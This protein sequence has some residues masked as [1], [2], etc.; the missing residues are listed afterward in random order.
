V[1]ASGDAVQEFISEDDLKTFDGWLKY[2]GVEAAT[3]APEEMAVLQGLFDEARKHSSA[4]PKVGLMKLEPVPGEH[5][6]AVAVREGSDLWLALWVRRSRKGEFFVML[7]RLDRDWDVHASYHLDGTRH[8]KSYD[9]RVLP[10]TKCQPLAGTF[11]GTENLETF[12]GYG[13]KSV[14]AICDPTAFSGVVEIAPGILGPRDGQITVDLV[15]PGCQPAA[16]PW[17]KITQRE[18]FRDI[19]PWVVITVGSCG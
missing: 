17:T 8:M 11:R 9:R 18:V 19:L 16:F 15:E 2:Q 10:P 7:P 12:A 3:T 14:G 4:K 5:R 6:Y 1:S 13:P